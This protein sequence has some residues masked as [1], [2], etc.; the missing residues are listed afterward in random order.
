MRDQA[1]LEHL[2]KL[3]PV[4]ATRT[5]LEGDFDI[6]DQPALLEALRRDRHIM[7]SDHKIIEL[8]A[9]AMMEQDVD[10]E[11]FLERLERAA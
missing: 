1:R 7:L 4:E 11:G 2:R 9:E 10:A 3:S 6:D 8:F 5:W